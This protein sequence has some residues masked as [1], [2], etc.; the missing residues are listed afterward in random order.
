[1]SVQVRGQGD[2]VMAGGCAGVRAGGLSDG[3]RVC[4]C[5]GR[6]A[7]RRLERVCRCEARPGS[8]EL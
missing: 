2:W 3:W 4:R 6:G 5:E 1:M 7:E 8:P